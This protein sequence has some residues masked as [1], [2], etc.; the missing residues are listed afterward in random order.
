MVTNGT[1]N[2]R[3]NGTAKEAVT[4]DEKRITSGFRVCAITGSCVNRP[5]MNRAVFQT[6][7]F[8]GESKIRVWISTPGCDRSAVTN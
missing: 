3:R 8:Q 1:C 2:R 7:E 4:I 5:V 6:I